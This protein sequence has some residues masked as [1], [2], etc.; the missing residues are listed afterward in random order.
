MEI[1][2]T[3]LKT[4]DVD[5]QARVQML[6][7]EQSK[8][9]KT[10][11]RYDDLAHE[12]GSLANTA[13]FLTL[14]KAGTNEAKWLQEMLLH[15]VTYGEQ[16]RELVLL[17]KKHLAEWGEERQRNGRRKLSGDAYRAMV[18]QF[19]KTPK[20]DKNHE[21]HYVS[22]CYDGVTKIVGLEVVDRGEPTERK[23]Q[24]Y[25][26][27]LT[28]ERC[29]LRYQMV[30]L[31]AEAEATIAHIPERTRKFFPAIMYAFDNE[32][33]AGI[34]E[35]DLKEGWEDI[36]RSIL[37]WLDVCIPVKESHGF[38][39]RKKSEVSEASEKA[40]CP[41]RSAAAK[42]GAETRRKRKALAA[43]VESF[44]ATGEGH[45]HSA[46]VE[47]VSKEFRGEE[48]GQRI[49]AKG[50]ETLKAQGIGQF[51]SSFDLRD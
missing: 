2:W 37:G 1:N 49:T 35:Y 21:G 11:G 15:K 7:L 31:L 16:E 47:T 45:K 23:V 12:I 36:A 22:T 48:W 14:L 41:K 19:A 29:P 43:A 17:F 40:V 6:R 34:E 33:N 24:F 30:E 5:T 10:C 27:V 13:E 32:V 9:P 25:R 3:E 38:T 18:K 20:G 44:P 28:G 50:E 42:K 4:L 8:L 39:I 46:V 26:D 51:K